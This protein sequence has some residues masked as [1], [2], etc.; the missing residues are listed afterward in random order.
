MPDD[1]R[2][3]LK[4]AD[5]HIAELK[6]QILIQQE[7]VARLA[8]RGHEAVVAQGYLDALTALLRVA[9]K[10]RALIIEQLDRGR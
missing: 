5:R 10:H 4:E 7:R 2:A 8:G 9:R 3:H 6:E 1:E